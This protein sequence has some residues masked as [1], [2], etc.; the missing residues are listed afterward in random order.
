MMNLSVPVGV[1]VG[2][3]AAERIAAA[4]S[5]GRCVECS[6]EKQHREMASGV[7]VWVGWGMGVVGGEVGVG[8]GGF[9]EAQVN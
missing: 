9:R 1:R 3:Q 6:V 5:P 2:Q 4:D 7:W 8:T